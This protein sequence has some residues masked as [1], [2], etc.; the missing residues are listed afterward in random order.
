MPYSDPMEW[1]QPVLLLWAMDS[2]WVLTLALC[3]RHV[4]SHMVLHK[5]PNLE[6]FVVL[7]GL[8]IGSLIDL[9]ILCYRMFGSWGAVYSFRTCLVACTLLVLHT[10]YIQGVLLW[11]GGGGES[12]KPLI[13]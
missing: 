6:S 2:A 1:V 7:P 5:N 13:T 10:A 9:A 3:A 8:Y 12:Q 11:Y 4:A